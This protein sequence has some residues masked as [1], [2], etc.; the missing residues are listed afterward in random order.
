MQY[1][2]LKEQVYEANL[3]LDRRGLVVYSFGNV[4]QV[5]RQNGV[6]AIK[7]S[8]VSYTEMRVDDMVIVDLDG[9]VIEGELRP[10]SDTPTHVYLYQHFPDIGGVTHTHSKNATAWAQAR[11][12]LPCL[13]TTHA[14]YAYGDVP[15][16]E[17][18]S[19]EQVQGGDY[20]KET[21]VQIKQVFAKRSPVDTPMVLVAGHGPFTWGR[22]AAQSVFH[23]VVLE[24]IAQMAAMTLN[25]APNAPALET[26]ILNK[27]YQRKHGKN[28]YYGQAG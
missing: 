5:D 25:L 24:E 27:H 21:G 3:E 17:V 15:C 16:T 18:V 10:S 19:K 11:R 6:V 26:A 2:Q 12:P 13:G 23:A 8:G 28:A 1:R 14:D 22:D 9:K 4:S 7:P 20:E